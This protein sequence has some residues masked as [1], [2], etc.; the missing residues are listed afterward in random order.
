[1]KKKKSKPLPAGQIGCK[2]ILT[3]GDRRGN[4]CDKKCVSGSDLCSSH[5]KAA[6]VVTVAKEDK[7]QCEATTKAGAQCKK[8]AISGRHHCPLHQPKE[9]KASAAAAKPKAAKKKD[10]PQAKPRTR[11]SKRDDEPETDDEES[12]DTKPKTDDEEESS[13]SESESD[14]E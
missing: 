14:E 7:K 5:T 12:R 8:N 13:E 11:K 6:G 9:E 10:V 3:R 4:A 1:L 2:F